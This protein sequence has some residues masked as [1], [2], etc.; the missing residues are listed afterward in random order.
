MGKRFQLTESEKETIKKLYN[1][2]ESDKEDK[3]FVMLETQRV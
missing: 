1:L 2:S 3:S